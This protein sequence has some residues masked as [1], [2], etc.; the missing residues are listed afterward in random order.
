MAEVNKIIG[1]VQVRGEMQSELALYEHKLKAIEAGRLSSVNGETAKE[2]D[3]YPDLADLEPE[4][5]EAY[6]KMRKLDRI[7]DKKVKKEKEVKRD[8]ILLE[9]RYVGSEC[10]DRCTGTIVV[11]MPHSQNFWG[12]FCFS[13][14]FTECTPVTKPLIKVDA[15]FGCMAFHKLSSICAKES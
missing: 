14:F 9:R 10:W 3:K 4:L 12:G 1:F 5:R 7:L 15:W 13:K 8:R 2:D 6:I 11:Q